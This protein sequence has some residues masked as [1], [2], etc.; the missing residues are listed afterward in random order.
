MVQIAIPSATVSN[1]WTVTG[2]SAHEALQVC[3]GDTTK[4]DTVT[5]GDV[6][7][8]NIDALTDPEVSTGHIIKITAQATGSGAPER[9]TFKLFQSTTEIASSGS[10]AITR[11]SYN[12]FT[13]TLTGTEADNITDYS[14]L[15]IEMTATVLGSETLDITCCSFE[16]PD[17]PVAELGAMNINMDCMI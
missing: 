13:Y 17:A 2:S 8:V 12:E 7:N 3:N 5:Q 6:C 11:D 16:V 10:V 1:D 9:I 14:I 4:I 15:R